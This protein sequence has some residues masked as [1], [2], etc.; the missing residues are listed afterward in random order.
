MDQEVKGERRKTVSDETSVYRPETVFGDARAQFFGEVNSRLRL[1][2]IMHSL[3]D[4][5]DGLASHAPIVFFDSFDPVEV[6]YVFNDVHGNK[7]V[8]IGPVPD[9]PKKVGSGDRFEIPTRGDEFKKWL[10]ALGR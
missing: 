7:E 1:L 3:F 6:G 5:P 2:Y 4:D 8:F 10:A 9:D